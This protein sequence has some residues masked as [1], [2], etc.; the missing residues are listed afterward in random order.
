MSYFELA[1]NAT[2]NV[3]QTACRADQRPAHNNLTIELISLGEPTAVFYEVLST[4]GGVVDFETL[5]IEGYP[6]ANDSLT[7]CTAYNEEPEGS[8]GTQWYLQMTCLS[9]TT[10]SLGYNVQWDC[11]D[12]AAFVAS[13]RGLHNGASSV[14]EGM[15]AV[16]LAA[17]TVATALLN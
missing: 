14:Y 17:V 8:S 7:L 5:R 3:T 13:T 9:N 6:Q 1:A 16:L 4:D 12:S 2:A 11:I 15:G 10:C